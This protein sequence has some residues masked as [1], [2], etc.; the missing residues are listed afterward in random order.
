MVREYPMQV[1]M[2]VKVLWPL[3]VE[4]LKAELAAEAA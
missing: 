1:R 2:F 4:Q 3:F